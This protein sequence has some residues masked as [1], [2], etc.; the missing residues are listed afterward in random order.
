MRGAHLGEE[1]AAM[2][3]KEFTSFG[4]QRFIDEG[5]LMGSRCKGCGAL[6]APPRSLC[7]RCFGS[8]MEWAELKGTG[9]LGA[10]TVIYVAPTAMVQKGYGRNRPY[11][12]AVV[13]LDEGP[14]LA[15]QLVGV[16]AAAP[17]KIKLGLP[18]RAEFEDAGDEGMRLVFRA[19]T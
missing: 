7:W 5:K 9:K 2:E 12:S 11:V 18:V 10:F 15:A 6:N 14:R 8:D 1:V 16:D 19:Q 13:E 3:Q 17:E 4:Y